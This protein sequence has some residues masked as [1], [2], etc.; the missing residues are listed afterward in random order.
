MPSTPLSRAA[1]AALLVLAAAPVDA[2]VAR[3]AE[4]PLADSARGLVAVAL[5]ARDSVA[6]FDAGTLE[7]VATLPVGKTPHEIAASP[8]GRRAYVADARDTSITV[9]EAHGTP[10]VAATWGLPDSI[11]VHDLSA[12][13]DGRT[14]WA[15]SGGRQIALELDAATG[16]VRRRFALS[17]PG[18]WLIDARGATDPVVVAHLEGAAVTVIDPVTGRQSVLE[19]REGEIDAVANPGG[20]QVWSVNMRDGQVTV[21]DRRSGRTL[22]REHAGSEAGRVLFTPDGR[23]V[24]VVASG[25]SALVALD[26]RTRQRVGAARVPRGPKVLALSADGRRAYLTHPEGETLTMVDLAT[27]AVLRTVPVPGT[28]DGVAV[29]GESTR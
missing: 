2:L 21:Y 14:V 12:S 5:S 23:T 17:R 9:I 13:A 26:A 16:R 11:R 24:L 15:V 19:A 3:Y 22:S 25:D 10:R 6:L 8:D 1:T 7:R 27:M 4:R 29:L 18:S 28:P 20:D